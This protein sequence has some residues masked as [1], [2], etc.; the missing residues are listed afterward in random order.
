MTSALP[1]R[2]AALMA[3]VLTVLVVL[4]PLAGAAEGEEPRTL[5]F[6]VWVIVAILV[7]VGAAVLMADKAD[8][9]SFSE[10]PVRRGRSAAVP[11]H[12]DSEE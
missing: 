5:D 2:T 8:D 1:L 6:P 11:M 10:R 7:I 9:A 12:D 4:P 3:A